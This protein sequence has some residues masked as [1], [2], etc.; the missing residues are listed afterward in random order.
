MAETLWNQKLEVSK[1]SG[2]KQKK[3]GGVKK[4]RIKSSFPCMMVDNGK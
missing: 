1:M 4:R 2:D 3:K